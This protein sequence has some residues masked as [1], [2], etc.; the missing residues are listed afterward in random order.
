MSAQGLTQP[1]PDDI[2]CKVCGAVVR[3]Y[4]N[5]ATGLMVKPRKCYQCFATEQ[6]EP[7]EGVC[8]VPDCEKAVY[9]HRRVC[10]IHKDA[11]W[12]G[13]CETC[14]KPCPQNWAKSACKGECSVPVLARRAQQFQPRHTAATLEDIY[15][16]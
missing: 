15:G 3:P 14:G 6:K 10:Y 13:P 5:K 4:K 7:G 8:Q 9:N 2:H 16:N 1:S 11:T 12:A